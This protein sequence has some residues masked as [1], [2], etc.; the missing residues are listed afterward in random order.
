MGEPRVI[1]LDPSLKLCECGCGEAAPLATRND[2][3]RGYVRGNAMRFIAGHNVVATPFWER[4]DREAG[5]DSC[6]PW[7]GSRAPEGYGRLRY[8]RH[9]SIAHRIAYELTRGPIAAGMLVCHHCDNPPC[10][11]PAHLFVGTHLDNSLDKVA[12]GRARGG[13]RPIQFAPR[14]ER[15]GCAR[16]ISDQVLEVRRRHAAGESQS[17][18][19]REFGVHLSTVHLIVHRKKWRHLP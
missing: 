16:L 11:N 9:P 8:N 18:L 3:K 19:A 6:W 5:P 13:P 4:V 1:G 12:K 15:H 14:G 10:C 17:S 7:M 2:P